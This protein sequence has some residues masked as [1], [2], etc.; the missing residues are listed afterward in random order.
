LFFLTGLSASLPLS[1]SPKLSVY[2][3]VPAFPYMA[4]ALAVLMLP[5]LQFYFNQINI[6]SIGFK[7][8]KMF[9]VL[10]IPSV[11]V[12]SSFHFGNKLRDTD[13]LNDIEKVE[14]FIDKEKV[15][16][17]GENMYQDW[18]L[19]AYFERKSQISINRSL[20]KSK[21]MLVEKKENLLDSGY[22][23][24]GLKLEKFQLLKKN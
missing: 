11:I 21:F 12:Y 22:F 17:V 6:Q 8:F 2:Y 1:V 15:L 9:G 5:T 19:I 7:I 13:L 23:D 10:L 16:S 18:R 24:T 14:A 3:L 20:I 4:M